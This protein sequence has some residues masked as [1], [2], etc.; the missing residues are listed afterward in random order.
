MK[1]VY[2]SLT[3]NYRAI[4]WLRRRKQYIA[5]LDTVIVCIYKYIY[6]Y[7]YTIT[8]SNPAMYCLRRRSQPIAL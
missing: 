4:V 6:I 3:E 8:V 1:R 7:I 5:Q 2:T